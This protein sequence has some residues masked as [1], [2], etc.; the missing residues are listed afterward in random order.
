[1]ISSVIRVLLVT[2]FALAVLAS[3]A[4]AD[5]LADKIRAAFDDWVRQQHFQKASVAVLR[6]GNIIA[7][8]AHGPTS[9]TTPEPVAS[10][11]KSITGLCVVRLVEM[12][13]LRYE[14]TLGELFGR[15]FKQF[16]PPADPSFGKITLAQLLTHT[17][18]LGET[19][20]TGDPYKVTLR[21]RVGRVIR[22]NFKAEPGAK[23]EYANNN[24]AMLGVV[25]EEV[26]GLPYDVA[27]KQ[28]VLA[29]LG[30]R[31]ARAD[32]RS[33][34]GGWSISARDD[35]LLLRY[36]DPHQKLLRTGPADWP[37]HNF[38][39]R[40][41]YS[42]GIATH[43]TAKNAFD[44]QHEGAWTWN[45]GRLRLD[46]GAYFKFWG[47]LGSGFAV[48]FSP[49]RKGATAD[50][51]RRI[52]EIMLAAAPPVAAVAPA[53]VGPPTTGAPVAPAVAKTRVFANPQI[54]GIAV[55]R[56]LFYAAQCNK[57]AA[58]RY[59]TLNGFASAADFKLASFQL[60]TIL[61][62]G[63]SCRGN[64]GGFAEVTCVQ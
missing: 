54:N 18:G 41:V 37:K 21:Q 22:V 19:D 60:T 46:Y 27:C 8:A 33:S 11:S 35:A 12:G 59:C 40:N 31:T 36:F 2:G 62:D 32:N 47:D 44:V 16:G 50:I 14:M 63:Q 10:V 5:P 3:P 64:C 58:D 29:P 61:G 38:A 48:N 42:I 15:V 26:T 34:W 4:A 17:S 52:K 25:I 55:D 57:P 23:H 49:K 30:I 1:M 56:C 51:E 39:A 6:N 9:A 7:Q 24:F 28:L 53:P 45:S 20:A 43:R 13:R